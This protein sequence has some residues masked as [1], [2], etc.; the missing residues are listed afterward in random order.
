MNLVL[1]LVGIGLLGLFVLAVAPGIMQDLRPQE[2]NA[3]TKEDLEGISEQGELPVLR[4]PYLPV[5][6]CGVPPPEC[7]EGSIPVT[8][9]TDSKSGCP[10]WECV[11]DTQPPT[12]EYPEP[13]SRGGF[14]DIRM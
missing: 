7:P 1:P 6:L 10:A 4:P 5:A 14:G 11:P 12:E 13:R 8:V 9:Q 2:D 3:T